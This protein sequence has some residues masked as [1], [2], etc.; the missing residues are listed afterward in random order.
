MDEA[1]APMDP[2]EIQQANQQAQAAA[3]PVAAQPTAPVAEQPTAP[4]EAQPAAPVAEQPAAPEV[5]P[6]DVQQPTQT[7]PMA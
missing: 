3:A 1:A 4:V 6:G 2:A 5:Q 7:N